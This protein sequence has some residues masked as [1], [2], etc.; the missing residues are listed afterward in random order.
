MQGEPLP[1]AMG[2]P[3]V[4]RVEKNVDKARKQGQKFHVF[5]FEGKVGCGKMAWEDRAGFD[6]N[7]IESQKKQLARKHPTNQTSTI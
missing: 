7:R 2:V 3:L 6:K 5:Y 4:C 1:R